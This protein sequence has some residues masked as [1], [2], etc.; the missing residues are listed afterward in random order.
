MGLQLKLNEIEQGIGPEVVTGAG[1]VNPF[2]M[3]FTTYRPNVRLTTCIVNGAVGSYTVRLYR[4]VGTT[5]TLI[6]ST[7]YEIVTA[8]TDT[9][10]VLNLTAP[11]AADYYVGFDATHGRLVRQPDLDDQFPFTVD[12]VISFTIGVQYNNWTNTFYAWY[13]F[14]DLKIEYDAYSDSGSALYGPY[15]LPAVESFRLSNIRWDEIIP[16]DTSLAVY[17]GLADPEDEPETW[18]LCAND[19]EIPTLAGGKDLYI[20]VVMATS[21]TEITPELSN[22]SFMYEGSEDHSVVRIKLTETGRLK[23]PQGNVSVGYTASSGNLKNAAG[24]LSIASFEQA[25]NPDEENLELFFNPNDAENIGVSVDLAV[26]VNRVTY[27]EHKSADENIEVDV[28]LS[29]AVYD[30]EDNPV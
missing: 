2:G 26:D 29:V 8:D 9:P 21:D 30:T 10:V 4:I 18:E 27:Y 14:Y 25:F 28:D 15:Q 16:E 24:T 12:G 13:Y 7:V 11:T 3:R 23:H 19:D 20:K 17:T 6:A 22:L 1:H 5:P